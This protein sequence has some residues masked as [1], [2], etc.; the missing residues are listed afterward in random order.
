MF[1]EWVSLGVVPTRIPPD[2][3]GDLWYA[4]APAG[5]ERVE[6]PKNRVVFNRS[7]INLRGWGWLRDRYPYTYTRSRVVTRFQPR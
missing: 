1:G 2:Y 3:A 5:M 4:G 6:P 7:E